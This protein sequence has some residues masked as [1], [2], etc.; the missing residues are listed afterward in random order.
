MIG[1]RATRGRFKSFRRLLPMNLIIPSKA[2]ARSRDD[3]PARWLLD[4]LWLVLA[5]GE[6]TDGEYSV[7]EQ[8]MPV[9][10]GPP[11]HVHPFEDEAFYIL[12]GEMTVVIGGQRWS[13]GRGALATSPGTPC[14]SSK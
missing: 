3:A 2:F 5:T 9:G 1:R 13:S 8:L 11:P 4:I 10:S 6:D 7:I 12:A 14:M